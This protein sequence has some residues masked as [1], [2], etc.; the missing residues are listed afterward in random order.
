MDAAGEA[1]LWLF[2]AAR[3]DLRKPRPFLPPVLA[4]P[5]PNLSKLISFGRPK[6]GLVSWAGVGPER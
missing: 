2:A 6:A 3:V 5:E 4:G 1:A